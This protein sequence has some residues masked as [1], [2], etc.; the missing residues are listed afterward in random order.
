MSVVYGNS[1]EPGGM[2]LDNDTYID[3]CPE[4][5]A[6]CKDRRYE[7]CDGAINQRYSIDC[8]ACGHHEC[9]AETCDIC[10]MR[11]TKSSK[12]EADHYLDVICSV[13]T[14]TDALIFLSKIEGSL[15]S[16][17][18]MLKFGDASSAKAMILEGGINFPLFLQSSLPKTPLLESLVHSLDL[19]SCEMAPARYLSGYIE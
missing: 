4:C 8:S 5:G 1:V 9:N 2:L 10:E 7:S 16:A 3:Q 12:D 13:S 19:L 11:F 14:L 6:N 15:L 18:A 17:K